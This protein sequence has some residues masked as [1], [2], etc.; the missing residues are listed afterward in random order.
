MTIYAIGDIHGHYDKLL[1]AHERV[2]ADMAREG[3]GSA[4]MVHLGDLVDRG[5]ASRDVVDYLAAGVAEGRNWVVLKGNHDQMFARAATAGEPRDPRLRHGI[6]YFSDVVGGTETALS[7]G[8]ARGRMETAETLGRRLMQAVPEAHKDF[9]SGL[10]LT[11]LE[12]ACL[13]VHAGI[14][15]GVAL[16][17]QAE[18][19]LV[20]IR[21]DFLWHL[22]D[23]PW[24]VVHGHTPVDEVSH[25]GNRVNLDTGAGYG[26]ALSAVAIEGRD[27]FLLTDEGRKRVPAPG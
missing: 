15:P 9:L 13:F 7:Y 21:D 5:P 11:Y 24:L 10:R 18:A 14:R 19:D 16:E 17:D 23:H 6:D 12:G 2:A 25:Y 8:V 4:T 27:V 26:D 3:T 20:W 1:A 22:S